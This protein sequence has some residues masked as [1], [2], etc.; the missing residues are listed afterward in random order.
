MLVDLF[1]CQAKNSKRAEI[2]NFSE[3][4]WYFSY[5]L[6]PSAHSTLAPDARASDDLIY[7]HCFTEGHN[8]L[9]D[10]SVQIIDRVNGS[11]DK[12]V[13]KEGQWA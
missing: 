6:A 9:D 2:G 3:S 1:E 11:V 7:R 10:V 12:P 4:F 5:K 8:G 13:E